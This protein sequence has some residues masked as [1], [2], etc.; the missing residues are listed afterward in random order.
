MGKSAKS[1][2]FDGAFIVE[3]ST[4]FFSGTKNNLSEISLV[5]HGGVHKQAVVWIDFISI[6][7]FIVLTSFGCW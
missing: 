7:V 3:N 2:G 1:L 5:Q 6:L 4:S